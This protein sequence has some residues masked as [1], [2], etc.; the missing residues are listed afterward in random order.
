MMNRNGQITLIALVLIGLF[1]VGTGAVVLYNK[2]KSSSITG[3]VISDTNGDT[4]STTTQ[5][6]TNTLD[7]ISPEREC[8]NNTILV[9]TF[10]R[11]ICVGKGGG[12]DGSAPI[13]SGGGA[14]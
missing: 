14:S 7:L 5:D 12:S 8:P 1:V 6:S 10:G 13:S 2:Q 11:E 9:K 3:Q 4:P